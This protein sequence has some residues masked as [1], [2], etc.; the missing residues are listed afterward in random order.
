MA[1]QPITM[2]QVRRILQLKDQGYSNRRISVIL[3]LSRDTVSSYVRRFKYLGKSFKDL[4]EMDDDSLSAISYSQPTTEITSDK[5]ADLQNRLAYFASELKKGKAT[6]VILWEEYR[7]E[8]PDGYGRSQFCD[9]LSRYL[10]SRKAVMHFEHAPAELMEFDFAGDPLSYTD[11]KTGEVIKCPVLV[12]ILPCSGYLYIEALASAQRAHLIAALGRAL[13]YFGG[14]PQMVRTDNLKQVV[15]KANR[16]EPTFEEYCQ[17]WSLHYNTTL[18]ATRVAK[19]RDKASVESS[20]NT[21]Y[22]RVYAPLRNEQFFSL[23]QLNNAI[24]E[25]TEKLNHGKF[26]N[27]DY[28]R[29]DKFISLEQ[30]LLNPLPDHPFIPKSTRT[31]KVAKNYHVMLGEDRHFYSVP[32]QYIGKQ[33]TLVYDTDNVEIY[34]D[35]QRIASFARDLRRHA[36]TTLAE[37]MPSNHRHYL[38]QKGWDEE[39]F[40]KKSTAIGENTVKA[41]REVLQHRTFIEQSYRACIGILRLADKYGKQR[42]EAACARALL[43][44]KVTYGILNKILEKG[45]DKQA[46]QVSLNFSLPEHQ[47]LRG[48]EAYS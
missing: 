44:H 41:I 32:Q 6:R 27:K 26:Q 9:Y 37:H 22:C 30:P 7:Q 21:A 48:A 5:Y 2:L 47:N 10:E 29:H 11:P 24:F 23:N 4:M 35:H 12:C 28:S 13:E 43:G 19:P 17:Q 40:L 31:A 8:V 38:E 34:I 20:V 18:T 25:K 16:Y 33:V 42:L 1:N 45:L 14:V 39:Y 36:Y 15:I 46:L 3:N